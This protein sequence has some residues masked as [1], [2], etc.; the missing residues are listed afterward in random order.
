MPN[1]VKFLHYTVKLSF[2]EDMCTR[3]QNVMN[4]LLMYVQ[5]FTLFCFVFPVTGREISYALHL[6]NF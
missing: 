5:V 1:I 4:E 6:I 2:A 3:S